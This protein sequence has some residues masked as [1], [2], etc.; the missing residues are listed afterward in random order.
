MPNQTRGVLNT[1][2]CNFWG[3]ITI[4]PDDNYG[5]QRVLE[6][7]RWPVCGGIFG[8]ICLR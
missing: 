1:T 8:D 2:I 3:L 4:T 7:C 5:G 6:H